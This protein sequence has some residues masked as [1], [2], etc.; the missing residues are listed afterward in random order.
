MI[1]FQ[2]ESGVSLKVK[3][4]KLTNPSQ[5]VY[6]K[7]GFFTKCLPQKR[8]PQKILPIKKGTFT[9]FFLLQTDL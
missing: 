6:L 4:S 7:N 1:I 8:T 2:I 5:N 3:L 9:N